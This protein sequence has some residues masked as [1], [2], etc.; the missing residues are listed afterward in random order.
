M[1]D[2]K[3]KIAYD[4]RIAYKVGI[5]LNRKTDAA[6]IKAL[7]A[8]PNK[9]ALIKEALRAYA[10]PSSWTGTWPDSPQCPSCGGKVDDEIVYMLN[11][12]ELPSYCP[13]CGK[14]LTGTEREEKRT[15]KNYK[16]KTEYLDSWLAHG[17]SADEVIVDEDEINRLAREWGVTVDELMEQVEEI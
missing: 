6:I 15:V 16:V 8:A 13:Y 14:N 10:I 7:E 1:P 11:E 17:D 4:A 9:Q 5:K 3:A 2:T 12:R